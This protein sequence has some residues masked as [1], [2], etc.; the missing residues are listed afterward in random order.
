M[1]NIA[2]QKLP[3]G[4]VGYA[5]RLA[6][7]CMQS[8]ESSLDLGG[9]V[10][11][12]ATKLMKELCSRD[13]QATQDQHRADTIVG[14]YKNPELMLLNHSNEALAITHARPQ[15]TRWQAFVQVPFRS[16]AP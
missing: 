6:R 1:G 14:H 13:Q 15:G 12:P 11:F 10:G 7:N 2:C 4:M 3:L 9:Q 5:G 16:G 8:V